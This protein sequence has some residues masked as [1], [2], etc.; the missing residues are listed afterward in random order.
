MSLIIAFFGANVWGPT[1]QRLGVADKW[2]DGDH[3]WVMA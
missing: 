3:A 2:I 1:Q